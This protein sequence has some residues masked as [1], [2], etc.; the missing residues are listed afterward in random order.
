MFKKSIVLLLLMG[1]MAT[2]FAQLDPYKFRVGLGVGYTNY[3][4]DL[5][6]YR[7]DGVK[8]L[9]RHFEYNPY[10]IPEASYSVSLEGR[11]SRSLSLI[12]SGGQYNMSMSDRYMNKDGILQTQL[13]N[14]NRSL[15]FQTTLQDA[16]VGLVFRTDNDRILNKNAFIAPYFTLGVGIFQFDVSGDLLDD[17]GLPYDYANVMTTPNRQYETDLRSLNTEVDGGYSNQGFYY[18]LGL[19]IRF[20]IAKQIELFVQS[21][22]RHSS[23][24]YLDDVSGTYRES[25]DNEFQRYAAMPGTNVVSP[26][27]R[28]RGDANLGN[29]WYIYHHAGLKISFA[30]SKQAFRASRV[31]PGRTY[32]ASQAIS[33]M[34]EESE[35]RKQDSIA[36]VSTPKQPTTQYFNFFQINPPQRSDEKLSWR[37]SKT[38]ESLELLADQRE[39]EF[40][41]RSIESV[42]A[43]IDSI[44]ILASEMANI[45]EPTNQDREKINSLNQYRADL[46][47]KADSLTFRRTL[48]DERIQKRSNRLDSLNSVEF[49][50]PIGQDTSFDTVL[51]NQNFREF[52]AQLNGA[53]IQND[54]WRQLSRTF[55]NPDPLASGPIFPG[56]S[57]DPDTYIYPYSQSQRFYQSQP[58]QTQSP[59]SYSDTQPDP[60]EQN[61]YVQSDPST[62]GR[63]TRYPREFR[64]SRST[65]IYQPEQQEPNWYR[66]NQR[67][68]TF[69]PV[70][71]PRIG[72]NDEAVGEPSPTN[73]SLQVQPT[74]SNIAEEYSRPLDSL[75][76]EIPMDSAW[77]TRVDTLFL[78]KEIII[79]LPNSKKEVYFGIN[80][81]Q[82]EES[83]KQKLE[84][85]V[86]I[87]E[88]QPAF[89]IT[90][91]GFADN[92]GDI[93]YNLQLVEKRV[94]HVKS[95]L[96]NQY[97]VDG[98]RISVKPGGLLIRNRSRASRDED[99]KVEI[100]IYDSEAI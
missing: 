98:D 97:K 45:D 13:P 50:E 92:T 33:E 77:Q 71:I 99:R 14:F 5:S 56:Q 39:E 69:A 85:V 30:P 83:E 27:N 75:N 81:D 52:Y 44:N 36:S 89:Y 7:A 16:G 66:Q 38:E 3:Y 11:I 62:R 28:L 41:T 86:A 88:A 17:A 8:N 48:I 9:L 10:Y 95:I 53:L 25:Y 65:T 22:F 64:Q 94:S 29:D 49:K 34:E 6:P 32:T 19:G 15:N 35:I 21:D 82:L 43:E 80:R 87:L 84:S 58:G 31:S 26:D 93:S 63:N 20:K 96:I 46:S 4:G 51:F 73:D 37:V 23:T 1:W 76:R 67:S 57:S 72:L 12:F 100:I 61:I 59:N 78:D 47:Q 24:D 54:N 70:F 90:L 2:S 55:E 42:Y 18:G 74:I 79:G 68:N 91:T 40:F 60:W